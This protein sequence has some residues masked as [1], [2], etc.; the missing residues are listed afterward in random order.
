MI[1]R[2]VSFLFPQSQSTQNR[3]KSSRKPGV[4][5]RSKGSDEEDDEPV[6][7]DYESSLVRAGDNYSIEVPMTEQQELLASVSAEDHIDVSVCT[8]ADYRKWLRTNDLMEYDGRTD[9]RECELSF[10]APS[11]GKYCLLLVNHGDEDVDVTIEY[12]VWEP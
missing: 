5:E 2:I 7:S 3:A 6:D 11:D 1:S 9:V 10:V 4:S 12:S 8:L